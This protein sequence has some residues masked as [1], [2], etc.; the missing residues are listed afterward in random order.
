MCIKK[1][2]LKNMCYFGLAQC[3]GALSQVA[4]YLAADFFFVAEFPTMKQKIPGIN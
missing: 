1:Y 3:E 4:V 2:M